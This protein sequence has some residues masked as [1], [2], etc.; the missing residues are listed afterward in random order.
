MTFTS[1]HERAEIIAAQLLSEDASAH[2]SA[3]LR[4]HLSECRRCADTTAGLADGLATLRSL[5]VPAHPALVAATQRRVREAAAQ[6]LEEQNRRRGLAV[7]S[8]LAACMTG[9][10]VLSVRHVLDGLARSL[11]FAPVTLAPVVLALWFLPGILAGAAAWASQEPGS[12][13]RRAYS[14]FE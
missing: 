14:V 7:S 12:V 9:V 10:A 8:L 13:S 4:S 1:D 3:W 5:S 6:R 11:E 2:D